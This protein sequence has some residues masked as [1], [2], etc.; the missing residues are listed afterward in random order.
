MTIE[1]QVNSY[2]I[3]LGTDRYIMEKRQIEID[4]AKNVFLKAAFN[5]DS[6]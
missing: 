4:D 3:K 1:Y 2:K 6:T 5:N